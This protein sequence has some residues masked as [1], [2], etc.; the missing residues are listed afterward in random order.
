MISSDHRRRPA[1]WIGVVGALALVALAVQLGGATA[2]SAVPGHTVVRAVSTID[3]NQTKSAIATCPADTVILGGGGGLVWDA[4]HHSH[5]VVITRMQPVHPG[6]G[7]LDYYIVTGAETSV[8]E[9]DTWWVDAYAVCGEEP[10]GYLVRFVNQAPSSNSSQM[11]QVHCPNAKKVLGVGA[12]VSIEN[13]QMGLQ[14]VRAS[15]ATTF[16]YAQAHEDVSGYLGDWYVTGYA[17]CVE[18]PDGYEIVQDPSPYDDSEADKTAESQCPAGTKI[19][20]AGAATGF[21]AP[22]HV[23]LTRTIVDPYDDG[24]T[25]IAVAAEV[26]STGTDWDFI[27]SQ[28]ICAD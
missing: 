3:S 22:G 12:A 18:E 16:S 5:A 9:I 19:H 17:V 28:V 11:A 23:A 15:L 27:V 4:Q 6:D 1:R 8:G 13:G 26:T 25:G 24:R 7:A 20:G 10:A 14:V 2:A 21:A